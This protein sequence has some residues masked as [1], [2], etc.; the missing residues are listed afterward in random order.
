MM[1]NFD[2][3]KLLSNPDLISKA[4]NFMTLAEML[5][6]KVQVKK[7]VLGDKLHLALLLPHDK[8]NI[9]RIQAINAL[10]DEEPLLTDIL[11]EFNAIERF[12]LQGETAVY[13]AIVFPMP[14]ES[15]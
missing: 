7:I 4:Q 6:A 8:K 14:K 5:A 11:P 3:M 12:N 15:K 13:C 9:N 1:R 10:I 2:F